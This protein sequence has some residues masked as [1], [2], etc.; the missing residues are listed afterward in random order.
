[1]ILTLLLLHLFIFQVVVIASFVFYAPSGYNKQIFPT[2]AQGLGWALTLL[3]F[4]VIPGYAV[5]AVFF[6]ADRS[7]PVINVSVSYLSLAITS[8][9]TTTIII[10]KNRFSHIINLFLH[11]EDKWASIITQ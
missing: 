3:S 1:M 7:L 2:W 5:F 6:K 10:E 11:R 8:T 4:V 9:I